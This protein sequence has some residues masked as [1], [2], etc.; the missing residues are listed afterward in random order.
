MESVS[1][2]LPPNIFEYKIILVLSNENFDKICRKLNKKF[3]FG[4]TEGKD[5]TYN[6]PH[7]GPC[8]IANEEKRI[9]AILLPEWNNNSYDYSVLAHEIVHIITL[10]SGDIEQTVDNNTTETWA[11]LMSFY[12]RVCIDCLN[13]HINELEVEEKQFKK[14]LQSLGVK[15]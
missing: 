6:E 2:E 8:I 13:E 5:F 11:Y 7:P 10:I 12:L 3:D 9:C 1:W 14:E 4:Y 15:C